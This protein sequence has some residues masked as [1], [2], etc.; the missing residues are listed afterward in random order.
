MVGSDQKQSRSG[1]P[2]LDQEYSEKDRVD[3]VEPESAN[4]IGPRYN[5]PM[6]EAIEAERQRFQRELERLEKTWDE[7]S[8]LFKDEIKLLKNLKQYPAP[9]V[10]EP[11]LGKELA[12]S[13]HANIYWQKPSSK[14]SK[15]RSHLDPGSSSLVVNNPSTVSS[16]LKA[17]SGKPS[18]KL[19]HR[20]EKQSHATVAVSTPV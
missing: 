9:K 16:S 12:Q 4:W 15:E 7:K 6:E 3:Q 17:M 8:K 5:F 18:T 20:I 19:T 10:T 11:T 13:T 1:Y 2:E 14:G